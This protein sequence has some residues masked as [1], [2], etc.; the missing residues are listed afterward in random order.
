MNINLKKAINFAGKRVLLTIGVL[1]MGLILGALIY[2][3]VVAKN[4]IYNIMPGSAI[5]C[6][7]GFFVLF[8]YSIIKDRNK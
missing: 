3:K 7:V 5:I 6:V 4:V 2:G 8:L 1:L